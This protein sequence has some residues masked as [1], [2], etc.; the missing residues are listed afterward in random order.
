[1]ATSERINP[2]Y[3]FET[4][5]K[6]DCRKT[7]ISAET[8]SDAQGGEA[9]GKSKSKTNS[10]QGGDAGRWDGSRRQG[11]TD[12]SSGRPDRKGG[13]RGRLSR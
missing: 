1:M 5:V 4:R 13:V 2:S 11:E 6:K 10:A 8:K 7:D 3:L 12:S 9:L